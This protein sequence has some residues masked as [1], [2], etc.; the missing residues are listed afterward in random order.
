MGCLYHWATRAR[1]ARGWIRTTTVT[2][3]ED[4]SQDDLALILPIYS[5]LVYGEFGGTGRMMD[6]RSHSDYAPKT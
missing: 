3:I 1:C 2:T 5:L 6:G 4:E